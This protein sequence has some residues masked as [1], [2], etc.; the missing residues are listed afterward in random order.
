M[1]QEIGQTLKNITAQA[2]ETARQAA[3]TFCRRAQEVAKSGAAAVSSGLKTGARVVGA[4]ADVITSAPSLSS[5]LKR[6]ALLVGAGMSAPSLLTW[7]LAGT[8]YESPDP[9]LNKS[10]GGAAITPCPDGTEE[11][12]RLK[13]EKKERR[14]RRL[15]LIEKGKTSP[16]PKVREAAENLQRDMTGVERALLSKHVYDQYDPEK[17]SPPPP[18]IGYKTMAPT[19]LAKLGLEEGDLTDPDNG[20]R[21]QVYEVDEDVMPTPPKYIISFRG[22]TGG[23]DWTEA[24]IPQ[25]LGEGS[26]YYW[27][28]MHMARKV[29]RSIG[30]QT[31]TVEFTGHSLGGGLASAASMVSNIKATTQNAAGLHKNTVERFV[32]GPTHLDPDVGRKL[33]NAYRIDDAD[34]TEMLTS[35]NK[36]PLVPDAVGTP[37]P[38]RAPEA[39]ISRYGLHG[40]DAVIDSLEA[41]KTRAQRTLDPS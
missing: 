8:N 6:G 2:S 5:G 9:Y 33:V 11:R 22:T 20:F 23:K 15:Q 34:K 41:G 35:L 36:L 16:D 25:S 18:P 1:I 26:P 37:R 31:N 39:G 40:V 7:G 38:L 10:L 12:K 17:E 30:D 27:K 28:A 24:N 13:K 21:A 3:G 29:A 19:D 4:G 14:E 32:A